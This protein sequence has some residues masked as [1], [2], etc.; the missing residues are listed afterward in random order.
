MLH[1]IKTDLSIYL[2][3]KCKDERSL[4]KVKCY[5]NKLPKL[6]LGRKTQIKEQICLQI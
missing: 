6:V 1:I 3:Y 5:I 4:L 2:V